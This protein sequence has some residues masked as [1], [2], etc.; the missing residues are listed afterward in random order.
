VRHARPARDDLPGRLEAGLR[1]ALE[2]LAADPELARLLTV[3]PYLDADPTALDAQ[4]EWMARFGKLLDGAAASDSRASSETSF[5]AAFLV[6]GVRFQIARLVL[7]GEASDLSRLLPSL[8]EGVL[9]HYFE[10][11]ESRRL[12]RIALA[13]H[14]AEAAV[15]PRRPR[16]ATVPYRRR[17]RAALLEDPDEPPRR[18]S[19]P[20]EDDDRERQHPT[21]VAIAGLDLPPFDG[22][23]VAFDPAPEGAPGRPVYLGG[24]LHGTHLDAAEQWPERRRDESLD[25][26]RIVLG[27]RERENFEVTAVDGVW[28]LAIYGEEVESALRLTLWD[29]EGRMRTRLLLP[30]A[31]L[32]IGLAHFWFHSVPPPLSP[33]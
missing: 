28:C 8:L 27:E 4:R 24:D 26:A 25:E 11:G 29:T 16:F 17:P 14:E 21:L 22:P 12:A 32:M 2:M 33:S 6:G 1:I 31:R 13:H 15:G 23:L 7:N 30:P 5:L 20:P 10:P 19:P 9:S 18:L 3:D